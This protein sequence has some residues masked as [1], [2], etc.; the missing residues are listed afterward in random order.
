MNNPCPKTASKLIYL[1]S[2]KPGN[3]PGLFI[4]YREHSFWFKMTALERF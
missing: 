2:L 4:L 3:T 1:K